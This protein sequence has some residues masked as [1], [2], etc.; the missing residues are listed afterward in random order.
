MI[1]PRPQIYFQEVAPAEEASL[2][3]IFRPDPMI[4]APREFVVA[5]TCFYQDPEGIM[6]ASS[7]FNQTIFI[8]EKYR[9]VDTEMLFM[10]LILAAL[11]GA[12]GAEAA[13]VAGRRSV[14]PKTTLCSSMNYLGLL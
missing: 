7:V 5:L 2:E 12:A 1:S 3:Y 8:V 6:H 10:C 13:G 11:A 4:P 14:V 9:L